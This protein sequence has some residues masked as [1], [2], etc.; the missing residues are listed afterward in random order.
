MRRTRIVLVSLVLALTA[1][2]CGSDASPDGAV[3]AGGSTE[4]T[5]AEAGAFPVSIEHAFGTT[6]IDEAPERV[7]TWGWGSTEAALALEH[8]AADDQRARG[9]VAP[10]VHVEAVA[11]P[12]LGPTALVSHGSAPVPH[13]GLHG[14]E[15]VRGGDLG[16]GG[17]AVDDL[18]RPADG[19][20]EGGVVGALGAGVV[21]R[22]QDGGC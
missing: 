5:T 7:V 16:V 4:P 9:V 19:L 18:H 11:H 6:E 22:P 13:A 20:D 12:Q 15:V 17:L 8:D 3:D 14:H 1:A 2:A 21:R 10:A